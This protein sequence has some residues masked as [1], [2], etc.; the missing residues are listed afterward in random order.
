MSPE[1]AKG[2]KVDHRSDLFSF[3]SVLYEMITGEAP[4]KGEYIAEEVYRVVNVTPEPLSR[5]KPS[6]SGGLQSVI[7]KL[8]EKDL[9]LRYQTAAELSSD[10][11]KLKKELESDSNV[12]S[13]PPSIAVLPFRDMSPRKDQEYFCEGLAEELINALTGIEQLNVMSRTSS[14][15]FKEV[16][17]DLREIG[18][19]LN[20]KT[21]LEGSVRKAGRRL[22]ITIQLISVADG[23]HL[24]SE[25]YDRDIN[26]VFAI[27]D[28]I[29]LTVVD[30]LK[31][32]LLGEQKSK[33]I[34]RGTANQEAFNLYLKGRYFWNRRYEVGMQKA[35]ECFQRSIEKDA[36]FALAYSGMAD[37]YNLLGFYGMLHSREAYTGAKAA[38]EKA[39]SIDGSLAEAH[40]SLGWIRM[41]FDRDWQAAEGEF[42][43]AIGLNPNYA[44]AH[45]WYSIFLAI[46]GRLD[47][48]IIRIK[49]AKEMDPLSLVMN[50][51]LGWVYFISR[52][53]DEAIDQCRQTIDMDPNF[54]LVYFFQGLACTGKAMWKEAIEATKRLMELS[55][56]ATFSMG[57]LGYQYAMS[58][59][60]AEAHSM[61]EKL[62]EI[63]KHRYVSPFYKGVVYIGLDDKERAFKSFDDSYKEDDSWLPFLMCWPIF[64]TVRSDPRFVALLTK[65]G[66]Q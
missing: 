22:R 60:I 33:L 1:Q 28:E 52:R 12:L 25:K 30:K 6:I 63:A 24:W 42:I 39:L 54:S 43:L 53:Y 11:L 31:V 44:T 61:L 10:L 14:F 13:S 47:E 49:K 2:V 45:E 9:D 56:G 23:Y 32:K 50:A 34:K 26:D 62:E 35:L 27:Q 48:A 21:V 65:I 4:F 64:D 66:L 18:R 55:K 37:C 20:V 46:M 16:S 58:G 3:G 8:L 29:S 59:Q 7:L 36:G 17:L 19:K 40:A 5:Y 51:M 41:F 15:Q 57:L 38:A